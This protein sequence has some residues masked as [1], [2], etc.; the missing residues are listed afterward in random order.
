MAVE[1]AAG[2]DRRAGSVDWGGRELAREV[3][4]VASAGRAELIC[5]GDRDRVVLK[6]KDKPLNQRYSP[7]KGLQMRKQTR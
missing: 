4:I 7:V 1:G 3:E 2:G 6:E 5:A